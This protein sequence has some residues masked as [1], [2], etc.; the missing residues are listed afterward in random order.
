M[1][2][3]DLCPAEE[4]GAGGGA[5]DGAAAS[6]NG[7]TG[8]GAAG[9]GGAG[10][11]AGAGAVTPEGSAAGSAPP[12]YTPNFKFKYAVDGEKQQEAEFDDL[13]KPLVKDAETEKKVRELFAK[14]HGLD[15]TKSDRDRLKA[16][17]E[18]LLEK[19]TN[20]TNSLAQLSGFVREGDFQSFFEALQIPEQAVLKYALD[21]VQYHKMDPQQRAQLDQHRQ[22]NQQAM[23][24]Q[25]QNNLLQQQVRQ[26]A[27]THRTTELET[28]LSRPDV[29]AVVQNFDTRA[30]KPGSFRDLVIQRGQY[31]A[32]AQG[33]DMPPS[34]VIADVLAMIG[35]PA[36][37][38]G[39]AP[40]NGAAP[41]QTT[42]A[43]PP[44]L[45]N[46]SGKGTSPAKRT[47]T[48][49]DDL[50]KLAAQKAASE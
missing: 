29:A 11:S 16:E 19:H 36:P 14:A 17:Y 2:L 40:G 27:A 41:A 12:P 9:G 7:S 45:P 50:R 46:V 43:A 49:T 34:Q 10:Q 4:G 1:L 42:R 13:F 35:A 37:Q 24:L 38:G 47:I 48:S 21:R 15:F 26:I 3:F 39:Q 8:D 23:A 30:G 18:P 25:Q 32:L 44:V 6:G 28:A 33:V 22:Q 20:I 5:G 31:F